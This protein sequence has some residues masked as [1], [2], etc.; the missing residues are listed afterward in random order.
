MDE[1]P[2]ADWSRFR[3][4][5]Q[6]VPYGKVLPT[7]IYVHRDTEICRVGYLAD[8]LFALAQGHGIGEEFNVVKFRTDEPRLSFL[9]YPL[10]WDV[11]HPSLEE[12]V[13][14]DLCSGR[15]LRTTYRDSLNPPI[16]HRKELLIAPNHPRSSEYAALSAAEEQAG[17]YS[18]SS[19]I[20]F[21]IN[22]ERLLKA[23]ALRIEGHSLVREQEPQVLGVASSAAPAIARHKTAL[24]RYQLSRPVKT[25]IEY[26]QLRP[27][28]SFFDYGCG[29]G[30]D[31]RGLR[32]LGFIAEGWDPVHAPSCQRTEAD[33]V[34]LGY[35]LNVIE[36][37]AERLETLASAWRL[38]KRLLVVSAL[39]G[40]ASIEAPRALAL[41]DG[42]V[43]QR[44]TFQRYF[45]QQ[46]LQL[47]IEDAL[48]LPATPVALGVFYVFRDP[49]ARQT[50]LQSRARRPIDWDAVNLGF[51]GPKKITRE[52]RPPRSK[53]PDRYANYHELL[54]E[55]WTAVLPLGRIPTSEEFA[56]SEDLSAAFGSTK[57]ALRYLLAHGRQELFERARSVRKSDLLVYLASSNLRKPIPFSQL[58]D[59]VRTDIK[60]F[61]GNYRQALSEGRD[62]LYSAADANNIMLA[63]DEAGI[64]WQDARNLYVHTPLVDRLPIV[65]RIYVACAELLYGDLHEADLVRIHKASGKVTFLTYADFAMNPLPVLATRTRVNLRTVQVDVFNHDGE[66]QLLYFKERFLDP[67]HPDCARLASISASL[68][69]IGISDSTFWGPKAAELRRRRCP[70]VS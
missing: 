26:A 6:A 34:N 39:I 42:V 3:Q 21:Q 49:S 43:T 48:E 7:A 32:E 2:K 5:L 16:L 29:L 35:V 56:R 12:A 4:L 30:A 57:R 41:N 23:H 50:F 66:G 38:A 70:E 47:Y 25:L 11:A 24:T 19:V 52:P 13:A 61:F 53:P 31:I 27:G 44:N 37:P 36:D 20:G 28:L 9:S 55:Y 18:N 45:G 63:C 59:N 68:R 69:E 14:I 8:T 64:G 10:F 62:L 17:L 60:E 58:P 51:A 67:E 46:E 15:A 1:V 54:E 22:W 40:D 33:V 65:L